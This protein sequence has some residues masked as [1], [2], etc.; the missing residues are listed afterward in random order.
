MA[1]DLVVSDDPVNITPHVLDGEVYA[2]AQVGNTIVLGGR[3]TQARNAADG[4][5]VLSR[6]NLLAFDKT[7]GEISTTFAPVLDNV[8]RSLAPAADGTSVYLAGQ[9]NSIDGQ[10]AFKLAELDVASGA[11]VS[12]FKPGLVNSAV[13][14]MKVRGDRMFIS[15][16]FTKIK[17]V[18]RV[19]LAELNATTGALQPTIDLAI[20]GTVWGGVNQA[21]KMDISPDLTR[22]V[23]IGNFTSVGGQPRPQV[24]MLDLTTSP[25]SVMN[26]VANQYTIKCGSSSSTKF[27]V[28]DVNFS[29]D[30]SYFII[31]ATGGHTPVGGLCDGVTRWETNGSGSVTPTWFAMT[32]GDSV[33]SVEATGTAVYA[34]GHFRW[35][36]NPVY[37]QSYKG[38]GAVDRQGIAALDPVTGIPLNW[39]PGRDRGLAVWDFLATSDGLWVANDTEHIGH[40]EYHGRIAMFPLAGGSPVPQP[41]MATLPGDVQLISPNSANDQVATRSAFGG[42]T[43]DAAT[44]NTGAGTGWSTTRAAFYANGY[45]YAVR[46]NKT[47]VK[48]ALSGTTYSAP[49]TVNLNG[50]TAFADEIPNVT[51]MFYGHGRLYY[52][53]ANQNSLYMRFLTVDSD[54]VGATRYTVNNGITGVDW[55]YAGG[56]FLTDGALFATNAADGSL[57]RITWADDNPV[58]GTATVVSGPGQDGIDWRANGGIFLTGLTAT[59]SIAAVATAANTAQL[60]ATTRS[61]TVPAEVLEG[62]TMVLFWTSNAVADDAASSAGW[63]L[64]GAAS[65]PA[66]TTKIWTRTA[67]PIDAGTTVSVSTGAFIKADL[68][69]AVYRGATL[70]DLRVIGETTTTANHVTPAVSVPTAGSWVISY[71]ADKSAATT[72]WTPP[73]GV[74]TRFTAAGPG[75]GHVSELLADS[76]GPVPSGTQGGLTAIANSAQ[77]NAGMVT[78]ILAPA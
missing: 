37:V 66:S 10:P 14:D 23:L 19:D 34:G 46:T 4:S 64:G 73:A 7:T 45:V 39:N 70:G 16:Q 52:T 63:T 11:R 54:I 25:V 71:W 33:Y 29:P 21:Y 53:V 38:P 57:I 22:M 62:D 32:G 78:V 65:T 42:T 24:A 36:N 69:L 74:T 77:R 48:Y 68:V 44:I 59:S 17:G 55:R 49:T 40:Y 28:R 27:D 72:S 9:F 35:F 26:W 18:P 15:G 75:S 60:T 56:A 12:A 13:Q 3:F 61:V 2:I 41:A 58:D 1:Q 43:A 5:P 30:G 8:V 20:T 47:M 76:G 31:G 51:A 67:G 6:T 50:L